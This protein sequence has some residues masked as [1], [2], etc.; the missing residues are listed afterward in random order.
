MEHLP[1]QVYRCIYELVA[2]A[3]LILATVTLQCAT[4]ID[5]Y[6]SVVPRRFTRSSSSRSRTQTRFVNYTLMYMDIHVHV[7][8][9]CVPF[10]ITWI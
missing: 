10:G 2:G 3:K 4:R 9:A 6:S 1:I 8:Y 5:A 7:V